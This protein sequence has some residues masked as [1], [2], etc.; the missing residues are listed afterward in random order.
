VQ[1]GT[2]IASDIQGLAGKP[3]QMGGIDPTSVSDA[4]KVSNRLGY[5]NN[6]VDV[7]GAGDGATCEIKN[8]S[9]STEGTIDVVCTSDDAPQT[10]T[11]GV[12]P[13][14]S[15]TSSDVVTTSFTSSSS[16]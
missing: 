1:K 5:D 6:P 3:S 7:P 8:N 14:N 11:I 2:S 9:N 4:S 12:T 10:V 15:N 16:P 13:S